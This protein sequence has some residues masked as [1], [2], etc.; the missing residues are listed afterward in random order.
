[1]GQ[2]PAIGLSLRPS[3]G[4]QGTPRAN[5][6]RACPATPYL[7]HS[8]LLTPLQRLAGTCPSVQRPLPVQGPLAL[9]GCCLWWGSDVGRLGQICLLV[10]PTP[11]RS[12]AGIPRCVS[13]ATARLGARGAPGGFGWAGVGAQ[14]VPAHFHLFEVGGTASPLVATLREPQG[15]PCNSI[16]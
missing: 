12:S 15:L 11:F 3:Q 8:P 16:I 2:E 6:P 4:P 14:R 7:P 5:G 9:K 13:N 1:M 10:A